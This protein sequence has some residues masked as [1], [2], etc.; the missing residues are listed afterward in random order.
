MCS[1]SHARPHAIHFN[2]F[3]CHA[4]P[5]AIHLN[6]FI[7]PCSTTCYSSEWVHLAMLHHTLFIFLCSFLCPQRNFGRHIVI[8]LSVRPSV[9]LC[10]RCISPIF[11]EVGIP[12]LVCG[13]ILGWRSVAYHFQVTVTLTLT[14]DLV[15][16]VITMSIRPSR[17]PVRCIS[18][19]FFEVG[20][21][22]LMCGC[23]LGWR[24]VAYHFWVTVTLTSDL[25]F[26]IIVSRAY[27]LY[28]L[29]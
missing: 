28:Y 20:I 26:R 21:P 16:I 12:N 19:I 13:C 4:P 9:P 25:A 3:F 15:F 1:F 18:P 23:I 27:L 2:E 8:A 7:L 5:H 14:S 10:V 17:F 22:N 11:F 29:R 6:V 24:S